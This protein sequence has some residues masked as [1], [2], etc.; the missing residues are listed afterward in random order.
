MPSSTDQYSKLTSAILFICVSFLLAACSSLPLKKPKPPIVSVVSVLPLNLSFT[1]Q[2]LAFTLKVKNPNP[3]DVPLQS[4]EFI[5]SFA[6]Q[7][8]ASGESHKEVSLPAN[9][10]ALV[11]VDVTIGIDKFLSR[12]QSMMSSKKYNLN[13]V[14]EG[15][16]KL[17]NWPVLIPFDVVGEV[18]PP[19][20]I[21]NPPEKL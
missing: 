20:A 18:E 7:E 6:D 15:K 11:E 5:A 8:M 21:I 17:A 2:K 19:K 10:E 13:Y 4:I 9:G 1:K 12:I 16:V 14:V 3:Y